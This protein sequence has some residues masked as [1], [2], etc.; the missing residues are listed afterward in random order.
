MARPSDEAICRRRNGPRRPP[1]FAGLPL[2]RGSV[3]RILH[4]TCRNLGKAHPI[5]QAGC[6]EYRQALQS[7]TKES[8]E[9]LF[10]HVEE[11]LEGLRTGGP[12][13][14]GCRSGARYCEEGVKRL[15]AL[16]NRFIACNVQLLID[17]VSEDCKSDPVL[18]P[19]IH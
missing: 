11:C 3:E 12:F 8:N 13:E 18:M 5:G 9:R 2:P 19:Q 7:L 6:E 15:F 14:A 10:E 1:V 4:W 17:E 16:R